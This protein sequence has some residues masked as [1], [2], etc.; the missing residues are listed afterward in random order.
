MRIMCPVCKGYKCLFVF[1]RNYVSKRNY[2]FDMLLGICTECTFFDCSK[3]T[4]CALCAQSVKGIS[5][6]LY[7]KETMYQKETMYLICY[8][9]F[10]VQKSNDKE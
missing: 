4:E 5:V 3:G 6:Y 1:K 8:K 2:V 9:K 10:A 7:S